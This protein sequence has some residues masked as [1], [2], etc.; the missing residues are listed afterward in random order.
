MQTMGRLSILATEAT[1]Q[2]DLIGQLR[3]AFTVVFAVALFCGS[4]YLLLSTNLGR[5]TGFLVS[6]SALTGFLMMLGLVWFTNLTPLSALHGPPPHWVVLEVVD[7]LSQTK[8]PEVRNIE[9][10]GEPLDASAQGEIKATIDTALT[11]EGSKHQLFSKATD[12]GVEEAEQI[13]G[14]NEGLFGHKPLYAIMKIRPVKVVEPL[15][16][17][18][19]PPPRADPSKPATYVILER[20]LGALRQPPLVMSAAFAILFALSLYMMHTTDRARQRA[21]K[22]EL[23]PTRALA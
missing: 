15:P 16:G 2:L 17:A 18:A 10:E 5:R 13:G 7:D 23:E 21:A 12:Y 8:I 3:G 9:K 22:G 4:I 11:T 19:P 20:D 14:G 1:E 6:F